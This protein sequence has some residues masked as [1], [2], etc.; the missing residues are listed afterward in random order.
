MQLASSRV[1][2]LPSTKAEVGW[3]PVFWTTVSGRSTLI[4]PAVSRQHLCAYSQHFLSYNKQQSTFRHVRSSYVASLPFGGSVSALPTAGKE[5]FVVPR[6]L[7]TH[8]PSG[9]TERQDR[10][11]LYTTPTLLCILYKIPT[12]ILLSCESVH[13]WRGAVGE[14]RERKFE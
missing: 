10:V 6:V 7:W 8:A 3:I 13:V 14:M 12:R 9:S 4:R 5:H 11:I 1:H 2:Q